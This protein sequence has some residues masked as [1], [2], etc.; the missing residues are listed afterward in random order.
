[1]FGG[2]LYPDSEK[3]MGMITSQVDVSTDDHTLNIELCS[4]KLLGAID[5]LAKESDQ[6]S[7][8]HLVLC[9]DTKLMHLDVES[10]FHQRLQ[11]VKSISIEFSMLISRIIL[12]ALF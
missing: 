10:W 1:M 3:K 11:G 7:K 9:L 12:F 8:T 6:P 5:Y 2:L 4:T